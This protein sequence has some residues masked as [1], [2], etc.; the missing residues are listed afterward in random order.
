MPSQQAVQEFKD[1]MFKR[2]GIHLS[3]ADALEQAGNLL[4]LYRAVYS[5]RAVGQ[6]P[7]VK[8]P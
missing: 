7:V 3:D 4:K 5:D 1:L 8:K 2:Y 6:V